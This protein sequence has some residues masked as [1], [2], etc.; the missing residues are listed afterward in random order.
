MRKRKLK[1]NLAL[2]CIV[3]LLCS[4][5]CCFI[6]L[7]NE[8]AVFAVGMEESVA[9]ASAETLETVEPADV[10]L[11][12]PER[13][14]K[15]ATRL[16]ARNVQPVVKTVAVGTDAE[17]YTET[18]VCTYAPVYVDDVF[19]GYCYVLEETAYVSI[20][21]YCEMLGLTC[22]ASAGEDGAE[23]YTVEDVEI[24]IGYGDTIYTAN[25]RYFYVPSGVK[26][27]DGQIVLPLAELQK[28]FGADAAYDSERVCAS[29]DTAN[30]AILE[31][32]DSFYAK[33]DLYWLSRIIFAESG[34]Q[35]LTGMIGVGNVVLNRVASDSFPDTIQGVVFDARGSIQFTPVSMGTIYRTPSD[36]A[37]MAAKLCVEGANTVGNSLY[38]INPAAC[39]GSWFDSALTRVI[40]IGDHVFYA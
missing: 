22:T 39:N 35:P 37:V 24:S 2:V 1:S 38:F 21:D 5:L 26:A 11:V 14:E 23:Q 36:E 9:G 10:A 33:Y 25:G 27:L 13:D 34:N 32:G 7:I 12:L 40:T 30:F 29:V 31:D 15:L 6:W 16:A 3:C 28:I 8:D 19:C 17:D 4:V 20:P 18:A